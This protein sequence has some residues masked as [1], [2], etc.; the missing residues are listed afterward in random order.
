[1][2][3]SKGEGSDVCEL[4][5]RGELGEVIVFWTGEVG[6]GGEV[7]VFWIGEVGLGGEENSG[8]MMSQFGKSFPLFSP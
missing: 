7:I 6:L 4:G 5:V 3:S 1:M 2:L 8:F